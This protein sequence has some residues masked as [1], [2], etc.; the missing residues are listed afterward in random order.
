MKTQRIDRVLDRIDGGFPA[1]MERLFELLRFPSIG[2]DPAHAADCRA[3]AEWLKGTLA[4]MGFA[5]SVEQTTGRPL[6]LARYEPP[7]SVVK[8]LRHVPHVLFYGHYDVQPADPHDLWT[9]PAFSPHVRPGKD[10]RDCIYARGAS[11]DKGQVMT[12]V[13]A[14]RAW[15]E[16]A[17]SLP[18]RLT[19][20]IEGDEEGDAGPLDDF[21]A[22]NKS[23]LKGDVALVCDT[24]L[25][26]PKTPM[27]VS[28][29]RGC[30]CED[31]TITGPRIDLHSGYFGGPAINPIKVLSRILDGMHDRNGRVTIPGFYDGV[32]APNAATRKAWKK[33]PFEEKAF[34]ANA[35]LKTSVG[36]KDYS[37][38]EQVWA[39]P[40]AE[41][42]G[43][44]GGYMGAGSKTVLP[45]QASAKLS[46][47][48]V[49]GQEPRKVRKAFQAY[50]RSKLPKDCKVTFETY[51][52]D[53]A[54]VAIAQDSHWIS[55]ARKALVDEWGVAPVVAGEGGSIPVVESFA[56]HL[57]VDSVLMGFANADDAIHSPDEK[58]D[59]ESYRKGIRSW[60]RM[61]EEIVLETE[62][63]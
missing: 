34:L 11:D 10:G 63:P 40:T 45:A 49:Q 31:V 23:R 55:K 6:V 35:G 18:F 42:N 27:I 28:S 4:R 5:A 21:L 53:S 52:G 62:K 15:L 61:I 39:R 36:E 37:V 2:T 60:A 26:D 1:S 32:K 14:S 19:M 58:Y 47:R 50:I 44:W 22:R 24:G 20:L 59:V 48:L 30:I 33:V 13:E 7:E 41:V 8:G 43:I 29:L 3:A 25:W 9:T 51:G 56:R 38:L 54:G 17:G 16:I 46:F 57:K 12:F